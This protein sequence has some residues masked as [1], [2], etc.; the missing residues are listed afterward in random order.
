MTTTSGSSFFLPPYATLLT[1]EWTVGYDVE[2]QVRSA[3]K[4]FH[5]SMK[6]IP[7]FF[8]AAAPQ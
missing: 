7:A 4:P 8:A 6:A 3:W 1:F 2:E 5:E